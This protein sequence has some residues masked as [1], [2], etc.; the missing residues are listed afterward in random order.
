L[1]L[2][3][4][5]TENTTEILDADL[6]DDE[7]AFRKLHRP[8]YGLW[9]FTLLLLAGAGYGAHWGWKDRQRL[10]GELS[11]AAQNEQTLKDTEG[12]LAALQAERNNLVAERVALQMSVQAKE[13]A[14]A[15]LKEAQDK[16]QEKVKEEIAKGEIALT[17]SG[18][19]LKVDMVD[20][21][22]FDS[23][24]ARI[25]K[26][27]EGVLARVGAA[28]AKLPDRQIQVVGHTDNQAINGKL[29]R[30]F[31]TNWELSASRALNVVRFL[32]QTAQVPAERMVASG[33]GQYQPIASNDS[34]G[35]RARNRRIEILLTPALVPE[36]VAK[37]KL[38][39]GVQPARAHGRTPTA[40]APRR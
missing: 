10:L 23:G 36:P 6:L 22:L 38:E 33:H 16:I 40:T 39:A 1:S 7:A 5:R 12:R 31:P 17:Q 26:R 20:K 30:Q 8:P 2:D 29:K 13:A 27:G 21:I 9:A 3:M 25:S 14:L 11:K 4:G 32:Q 34:A 19:R 18:G 24:D 15:Q 28:L 37:D 35:G